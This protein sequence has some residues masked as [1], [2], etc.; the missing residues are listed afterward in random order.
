MGFNMAHGKFEYKGTGLGYLWLW[1]WTT[2]LT[3]VTFGLFFP[4]AMT[5]KERWIA[6]NTFIDDKQLCFKGSGAGLFANWVLIVILSM[7]TFGIY[8][9]WGAC[10]IQRWKTNN[11]YFADLG[12]IE[13]VV[14]VGARAANYTQRSF[15]NQC[16]AKISSEAIYCSECGASLK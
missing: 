7:I 9:P 13:H 15:C 2:L 8:I 4:W 1:I 11:T 16:G 10:R 6:Q 14:E 12:D 3:I 5:S